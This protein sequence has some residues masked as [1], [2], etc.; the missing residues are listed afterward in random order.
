[1]RR[2]VTSVLFL[3]F[4]IPFGASISGCHH[5]VA[6]TYCNGENSGVQ[7]GQTTTL[8]LEPRLTGISL[9]QGQI[10]QANQPSGKDCKGNAAS[11]TGTVYATSNISIADVQPNSGRLCGGSWNRNTGGG[12][13]DFT[14]CTPTTQSGIAYLTASSGGVVSNP[15][16]VFIHPVVTSIVLGPAGNCT[17]DPASNCTYDTTQANGCSPTPAVLPAGVSVYNGLQCVSQGQSTQLVARAYGAVAAFAITSY[18]I[19]AGTATFH[20]SAQS[21]AAGEAVTLSGFPTSIFL[22]GQSVTVL[23]A[24]L[25]TTTFEAAVT[26]ATT[27]ASTTEAGSGTGPSTGVNNISCLVGPLTFSAQNASTVTIDNTQTIPGLATA[28]QPG[29]TTINAAISQASSTAGFFAT[30]PPASIVFTATGS[31]TAP[32]A[33]ITVNQNQTATFTTTVTDTRGNPITSLP[34]TYISTTPTT[35]P[36]AS[37]NITPPYPGS[38][39]IT[40]NCIPPNCNS[41]PFNEIGLYGTGVSISSNPIQ[42]NAVGTNFNTVLYM[43]SSNSQYLLPF[44][45]TLTTQAAPIRLP[46]VPNSFQLSTDQTS[47]YMGTPNEIMV[48]STTNNSLAKEDASISGTVL[49]VSPDSSLVVI[50]DP[51]RQLIYLYSSGYSITGE[52]GGVGVSA[53]WSADSQTVYIP[54]TDGRLLVYSRFTGWTSI[55]LTTPATNVAVT[56]PNAGIYMAQTSSIDVRTNCPVTTISG[57]GLNQTTTNV[58][59]PD[60]GP[61][62]VPATSVAATNDGLHIFGVNA[63]NFTDITTNKKGGACPVPFTSAPGNPL[64]LGVTATTVNQLLTTSDSA[65]AF[66][67]Y[68]GGT[69][70]TVPEYIQSTTAGIPGTL[71]QIPLKTYTTAPGNPVAGVISADNNTFYV[72]GGLDG[73]VH[74]LLRGTN[75][76]TDSQAPINPLL[77]AASGTGYAIPNFLAQKPRKST[78]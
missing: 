10:G 24:G 14:F 78:T 18:S 46:Y 66:V 28:A 42:I 76:F 65:Y 50:T 54:T 59:Y 71:T 8:D 12:I 73:L 2:F 61:V 1:M 7:V 41:A 9:N 23:S 19:T 49:S 55:P 32:T 6:P 21:L 5:A 69:S 39:A 48:F 57:T 30:C 56:V 51:V 70:T 29:S 4:A 33:P 38:A 27:V 15:I 47:I 31:T 62:A 52:Y 3:L 20:T 67:T 44:D 13:A 77:P 43:A 35:L 40:A 34:L 16:P 17:T 26:G 45:F 11:V 22:N 53:T 25:T 74:R 68:T 36:I 37:N 72:S 64:P 63:S 75:G 60:L 58:F